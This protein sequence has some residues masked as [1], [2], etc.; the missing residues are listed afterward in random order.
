[1]QFKWIVLLLDIVLHLLYHLI[2]SSLNA[3]DFQIATP[4]VI[5]N[6]THRTTL[7]PTLLVSSLIKG[8]LLI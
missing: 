5:H 1:M 8:D 6:V 7:P 3:E 2:K 4:S